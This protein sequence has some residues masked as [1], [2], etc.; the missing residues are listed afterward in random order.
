MDPKLAPTI[1]QLLSILSYPT[2]RKVSL[3][4]LEEFPGSGEGDFSP[5][6]SF[7]H[8]KELKLG[9]GPR[10]ILELLHRSVSL[11]HLNNLDI[12]LFSDAVE[13]LSHI[14]GPYLRDYL[15]RRG[16]ARSGLGLFLSSWSDLELRVGDV[17][18]IGLSTPAPARM[19]AFVAIT[20]RFGETL[21]QDQWEKII[22]N[23]IAYVPREEVVHLQA[24]GETLGTEDLPTQFPNLRGLHFER[25]PLRTA[26]P[27]SCLDRCGRFF[28]SLQYLWLDRV[29]VDGGN[30]SS[31]ATSLHNRAAYGN[32]LHTLIVVGNYPMNPSVWR[33]FSAVVKI[34]ASHL[35][36]LSPS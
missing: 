8:L 12:T 24:H 27:K 15:R 9:E 35:D 20:T 34:F 33:G 22:I 6:A 11:G 4:G 25:T 17:G 3:I 5:R 18:G 32:Q 7:H 29:I 31:L 19:N 30:W 36:F 21:P 28:P 16:R 26:F 14:I 2:L 13:D 23:L 10:S 1:S